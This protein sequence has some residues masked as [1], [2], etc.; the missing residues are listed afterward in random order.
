MLGFW[1]GHGRCILHSHWSI[2]TTGHPLTSS[3]QQLL[4]FS[5]QNCRSIAVKAE[6]VQKLCGFMNTVFLWRFAVLRCDT[7]AICW[8]WLSAVTRLPSFQ[9]EKQRREQHR[10]KNSPKMVTNCAQITHDTKTTP[11]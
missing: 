11:W 8:T 10:T 4:I 6:W 2:Q 5:D 7:R 1:R 3:L 9:L